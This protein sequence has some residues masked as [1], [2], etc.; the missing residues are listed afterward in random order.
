MPK[1]CLSIFLGDRLRD[2][3]VYSAGFVWVAARCQKMSGGFKDSRLAA[4]GGIEYA[5]P[6]AGKEQPFPRGLRLRW[7][8]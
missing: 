8:R 7:D 5:L 2:D 3:R 4:K 6:G 1:K